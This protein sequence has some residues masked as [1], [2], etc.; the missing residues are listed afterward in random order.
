MPA[1]VLA[2]AE[3]PARGVEQGRGVQAARAVEDGLGRPE[4]RRQAPDDRGL[5]DRPP[6]DRDA[7]RTSTRTASSDALPQTPQLDEA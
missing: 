2:E 3:Q 7:A 6:R 5:D 1:D 4:G